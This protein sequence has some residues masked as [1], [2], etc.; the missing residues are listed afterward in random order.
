MDKRHDDFPLVR[1]KPTPRCGDLLWTR[2]ALNLSQVIQR[3][4][5]SAKVFFLIS[6]PI[7]EQSPQVGVSHALH[8]MIIIKIKVR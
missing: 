3:S 7:C 5:L 2:L 1:P 8:K 6:Q 4:N